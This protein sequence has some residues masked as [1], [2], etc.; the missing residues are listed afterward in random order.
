MCTLESEKVRNL[1][2]SYYGL[3]DTSSLDIPLQ[4]YELRRC[5]TCTLEFA[6][7]MVPGS[8]DFYNFLANQDN[9]YP[10]SRWEY[11]YVK[12]RFLSGKV[13]L[14]LLDVGCGSG[15]FLAHISD[16][17]LISS[18]GIDFS[19]AAVEACL[20]RKIKAS[21]RDVYEF[22]RSA[23]EFPNIAV[24]FHCLEHVSNPLQFMKSLK[25]ICDKGGK[26]LTSTPYSP[27]SFE[28][29]WFDIL[30]HPPHHLT[31]WNTKSYCSLAH[32]LGLDCIFHTPPAPPLFSV[33]ARATLLH[34]HGVKSLA[35]NR[36][37]KA[38]A[39]LQNMHFFFKAVVNLM[40]RAKI[41]GRRAADVILVEWLK[42]VK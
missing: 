29:T 39:I 16:M 14:T 27:M 1:L 25:P 3:S 37:T 24:S 19:D 31:R 33:A 41:N 21:K 2:I 22:L 6:S 15:T 4:G 26:I 5:L 12:K 8:H 23:E 28:L 10:D 17:P 36:G 38:R 35:W 30:N 7:P 18:H 9:Y 32:Q 20:K 34:L 40:S 11:T 13:P 42:S